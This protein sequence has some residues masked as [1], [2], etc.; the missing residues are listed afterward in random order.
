MAVFLTMRMVYQV[1]S[2]IELNGESWLYNFGT[3]QKL[4]L[5]NIL[6]M[7]QKQA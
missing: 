4:S 1:R 5:K 2:T 6:E 3:T 7:D